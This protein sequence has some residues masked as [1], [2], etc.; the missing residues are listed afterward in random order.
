MASGREKGGQFA[1]CG[2]V[3]LAWRREWASTKYHWPGKERK[4]PASRRFVADRLRE[5][6]IRGASES[7]LKRYEKGYVSFRE[8]N[9]IAKLIQ[10]Y[11]P[12]GVA[13]DS[14]LGQFLA[15]VAADM[16]R[17]LSTDLLQP[18]ARA[19]EGVIQ[20]ALSPGSDDDLC[21]ECGLA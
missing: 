8:L 5:L 3:L 10:L 21:L 16:R 2:Q 15:A 13:R 19:L 6:G 11:D 4:K 18:L 1:H 17:V 12:T 14:M 9:T 7:S 20:R